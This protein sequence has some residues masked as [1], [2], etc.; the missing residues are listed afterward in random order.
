ML[1]GLRTVIYKVPDL[2]RGKAWY[3]E[4][5]GISPYFD[6]PFY[7]GF[8]VG[9]FELGLDPDTKGQSPGPGGSV[10]YWGVEK[11]TELMRQLTARGVEVH[12]PLKDVGDGILVATIRDPFGNVVG[13][14]E[15][16]HFGAPKPG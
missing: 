9:G 14:I 2:A 8:D 11:L 5:F 16:P 15:N 4:L 1:L 3:R 13:L 6:E 10:A 7:V 12:S